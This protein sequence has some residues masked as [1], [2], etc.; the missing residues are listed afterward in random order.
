MFNIGG[1]E[2][3]KRTK[4]IS[5]LFLIAGS[6]ILM[7]LL[8]L[9]LTMAGVW[10]TE[11]GVA[12][13]TATGSQSAPQLIS[14][15]EGGAIITW[16]DGRTWN[17]TG[18]DIYVQRVDSDGNTMWTT[19]GVAICTLGGEQIVPR[20]VSD[21]AGGAIITWCDHRGSNNDIYAQR[22]DSNG[23]T[24]WTENGVLV[25]NA[26]GDQ[27][28][29]EIASDGSGGAIITW[30]HEITDIY[31]Q[32][33][34]S[35]GTRQWSPANGISI[36]TYSGDQRYPKIISDDS[37]G[38]IITW[39]DKRSGNYD[40]YAQGVDSW[41]KVTWTANGI[42]ICIASGNQEY[43]QIT[44][45]GQGGAIITWQD[46]RGSNKDIYAQKVLQDGGTPWTTN[47]VLVCNAW[48]DQV[49]PQIIPGESGGAIITW[50]DYG[51]YNIYAQMVLTD[52][53]IAP[54]WPSNGVAIST[55]SGYQVCPYITSDGQGGAII[56]WQDNRNGNPDVYAQR[57]VPDGSVQWTT[58]GIEVCTYPLNQQDHQITSDGRGGA[59][60][61]WQDHRS[62]SH[63][64]VY[65]QR[66]SNDRPGLEGIDPNYGNQ[67]E[68]IDDAVITGTDFRNVDL[69]VYLKWNEESIQGTDIQWVS[70]TEVIADFDLTGATIGSDWVLYFWHTDD[71][72]YDSMKNAFT[73]LEP[74][75][76]PEGDGGGE[77][78]GA[79]PTEGDGGGEPGME[80]PV[81]EPVLEIR[82]STF[83]YLPEGS[84][85]S[86]YRGG[87]E[88]W[89][90]LQ[91]PGDEA[92]HAEITYMTPEGS[93]DGPEPI[94]EPGTRQTFN[95]ADTI[96]D[97]WSISTKVES[98]N[99]IVAERAMYWNSGD[100]TYRRSAHDSIGIAD[101]AN[102]WYLAE[103][104]TGSDDQGGFQTW[105]LVQNPGD[106]PANVEL[107]YMTPEGTVDGP[108]ATLEPGTRK[109]F[110]VSEIVAANWSVSTQ[111]IS[112]N[113]IIVERA[114]YWDT[115][116][117]VYRQSAHDSIGVSGS[118]KCWFPS[119]AEGSTGYEHRG[120]FETWV[121]IQNP[122]K[123]TA[124]IKITYNTEE[125]SIQGPTATL[126]PGS[127]QS[128]NVGEAVPGA[129]SVSTMITSDVPVI[130]ERSMYWNT[131]D[132]IYRQAG[133]DSIGFNPTMVDE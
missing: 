4:I 118:G 125:K 34:D 8:M 21:N 7:L 94:L 52:G 28:R 49:I 31:A 133:H 66:I 117:G 88:T 3:A 100:E 18:N 36:C 22:V 95:V 24:L 113:P 20:I 46:G 96:P 87:F 81:E 30:N 32:R 50:D 120:N 99:C 90:L 53:S 1:T 128:L 97:E 40:I 2:P 114:M 102:K 43:T 93:V 48:G 89:I 33:V 105:V 106:D 85:G 5:H 72:Q 35:S 83:W 79:E 116:D 17:V 19:N 101:L 42:A 57:I 129:W 108:K 91:N 131:A 10:W 47:G 109:T 25:S 110:D 14:D 54:R 92:A 13:S 127:R 58:N 64:D 122:G 11:G 26:S 107:S 39:N 130:A 9:A 60:I 71:Q 132:G 16:Y 56:E 111:V 55:A 74:A 67:G 112:D 69:A 70:D 76:E 84:T 65:A 27:Y 80:E 119:L 78:G 98:D 68:L 45:D 29:P 121:L 123:T 104:S 51:S 63:V 12:I 59:I 115:S 77:G 126:A 82:G 61:A 86:D 75:E 37:G 6:A 103:G 73:V 62:G 15:G 44:S 23:N 124:H 41:G 38:A